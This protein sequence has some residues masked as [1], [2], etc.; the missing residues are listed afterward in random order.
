MIGMQGGGRVQLRGSGRSGGG[1]RSGALLLALLRV[2]DRVGIVQAGKTLSED[3]R[4]PPLTCGGP[5]G[6]TLDQILPLLLRHVIRSLGDNQ[7]LFEV[8][9]IGGR[10]DEDVQV[11]RVL[12]IGDHPID[13]SHGQPARINLVSSAGDHAFAR[14]D[15]II[16]KH[17]DDLRLA[18]CIAA[19]YSA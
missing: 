12:G 11:R 4:C 17:V 18:Q 3:I 2:H 5:F 14:F 7:Q 1:S 13:H 9:E 6:C 10:L 8:T 19:Q 15:P 16:G